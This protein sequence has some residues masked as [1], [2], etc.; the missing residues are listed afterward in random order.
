MTH[1]CRITAPPAESAGYCEENGNKT[2]A[3]GLACARRGLEIS[4]RRTNDRG[5]AALPPP[6]RRDEEEYVESLLQPGSVRSVDTGLTNFTALPFMEIS[7]VSMEITDD[8]SNTYW[9]LFMVH[10]A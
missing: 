7:D 3:F 5:E 1:R 4:C 10:V 6:G 9:E 8:S 2:R